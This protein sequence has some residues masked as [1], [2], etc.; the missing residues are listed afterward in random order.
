MACVKIKGKHLS[1]KVQHYRFVPF[2][3]WPS[4]GKVSLYTTTCPSPRGCLI[5]LIILV[6]VLSLAASGDLEGLEIWSL[7]GADMN[8]PG[9]D[10]QTA[11]QVVG[12]RDTYSTTQFIKWNAVLFILSLIPHLSQAQAVGKTEVVAYLV[13]R[14]NIKSRVNTILHSSCLISII[15]SITHN[16]T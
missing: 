5:V 13:Q 10:G 15:L 8:K 11:V 9:Y 7:A 6:Y 4:L 14:M 3:C 2:M 12:S 1:H 16:F